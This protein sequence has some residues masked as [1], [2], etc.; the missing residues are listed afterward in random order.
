MRQR[1]FQQGETGLLQIIYNQLLTKKCVPESGTL[2]ESYQFVYQQYKRSGVYQC[3]SVRSGLFG[4][5][6]AVVSGKFWYCSGGVQVCQ[7]TVQNFGT[8]G[9]SVMIKISLPPFIISA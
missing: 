2:T 7:K 6:F 1:L 8:A 4:Q 3:I 5:C 9:L